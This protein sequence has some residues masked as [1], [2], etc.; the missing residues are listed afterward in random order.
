MASRKLTG[1]SKAR[2]KPWT[3]GFLVGAVVLTCASAQAQQAFSPQQ[4]AS[5]SIEELAN[6]E[7]TSVAR[8]AQ[9]VST[10]P[11]SIYVITSDDIRR[12]GAT[13]LPEVLRLA[14]NL[15]VARIDSAQYAISARGFNNAVGN[16]LLVRCDG[17]LH[18]AAGGK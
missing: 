3:N 18:F 10:A 11:A 15:Q 13:S 12:S 17:D 1:M 16:K 7:I 6:L 4:L 8:R 5:L 9:A 14:P 2:G